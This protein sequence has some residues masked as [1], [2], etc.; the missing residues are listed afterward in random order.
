MGMKESSDLES[1]RNWLH[2]SLQETACGLGHSIS[3]LAFGSLGF[4]TFKHEPDIS[5]IIE[6][7]YEGQ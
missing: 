4:L 7:R 3:I 2:S 6:W 1:V 5:S